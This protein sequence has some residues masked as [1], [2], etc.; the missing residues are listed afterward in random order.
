MLADV[1]DFGELEGGTRREGAFAS[2]LSYVLKLG[3]TFTLLATGP[4]VEL[5]GFEARK[6]LQD[7]TTITKLRILFAVLPAAASL[8]AALAMSRYP[9]TRDAMNA[10][11]AR[12]EARR[13]EL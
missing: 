7:T 11:R 2:T 12:L 3:T 6:A 10:I 5:T 8:L 9:L 4:L 13:G 1:V